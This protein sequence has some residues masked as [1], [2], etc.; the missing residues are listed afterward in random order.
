MSFF[1][2]DI[3]GSAVAAFQEASDTTSNNIA[4]VNTPGASR[5]IV[6]LTES[7]PIVGL[8]GYPAYSGGGGTQGQGVVVS[9]IQRIHDDSYDGLFRGATSS[10]NFYTIEQQQ[11]TALQS[12]FGEPNNGIN[13]A[14]TG[15]QTAISN[16]AAQPTS[17]PVRNSLLSS[18]QTFVSAL[19]SSGTAIQNTESTVLTQA[20]S[21]VTQANGYIDQIA[22]LNG[23]I[24]AAE[25]VGESP[26][27]YQDQ[28]DYAIDQL[29][30]L[31]STTTSLQPDGS[32][33]VT[34]NGQALVND[35]VAYHLAAPVIGTN[36]DGTPAF[37]IGF[38]NDPNPTN[39]TAVPLGSGQLAA[40]ADLYNN[41]LVP[42]GTS[43]DNFANA[44]A[45]E[46]DR[47]TQAGVDLNGNAGA[48]LL[49]PVVQQ[50]AISA[51][52]IKV[53][54]T[55]PSQVP[56][57]LISTAAGTLTTA[58]NSANNT[59][60]SS[61]SITGNSTLY[62][63][64]PAAGLTGTISVAVDGITPSAGPPPVQEFTYNTAP[65]GNADTIDDFIKNFNAAQLGVTASFDTVGQTIVF[66][67]DPSN[68]SLLHRSEQGAN[69]PT[70]GFT[71]TD[72]NANVA[73]GSPQGTTATNLLSVLGA[74]N[75]NGVAQTTANAFGSSDNGAA[76]ALVSL[77]SQNVG[78][79]SVQ[80]T[81]S[82]VTAGPLAGQET[83][84]QPTP[85]PGYSGAFS[86]IS[87]GQLLTIDAGTAT[88]E[89]VVVTAVDRNA[90]TFTAYTTQTHTAGATITTAQTQTLGSAYNSLIGTMGL[91]VQ[92][93]TTGSTAQSSLA[94]NINSVRQSID[95]INLDEETQNLIKYQSAYAAAA[96]TLS[97]MDALVQ[98]I[99]SLG[100][101]T[102]AAP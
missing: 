14:F 18:A 25:A 31:I 86:T 35:T 20:T 76:N 13:T 4:N 61:A 57:G 83:F 8:P 11:L 3:A 55:D 87:V 28:R 24:R 19:N 79:G 100:G 60:D 93:A 45:G 89:N 26:N 43:L 82:A 63:P 46:I 85:L 80:T 12:A 2:I 50:Q 95:G 81:A 29:S 23:E 39:P 92:T 42:Y 65:G 73:A 17:I 71:I 6:N 59:V 53:G 56:A 27:T 64:A 90:G 101:S 72:S 88:Q 47:I 69:A 54:I 30:Q 51:A 22:Q 1:G 74:Q 37:K 33:L 91:D 62:Y 68:I 5:Q 16:L 10:S 34:V 38:A 96:K 32:T 58:V 70:T 77:F 7:Q 9:Q 36:T 98:D 41:K 102:T 52:N 44:A 21:T 40:Y 49:A 99:L 97:T 48:Q 15:L 66:T 75:I 94:S 67:R 84:T 78:I